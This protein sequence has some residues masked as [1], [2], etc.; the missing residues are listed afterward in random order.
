[1]TAKTKEAPEVEEAAESPD[2]RHPAL[3][4]H[5]IPSEQSEAWKRQ[6]GKIGCARFNGAWYILRPLLRLE[7]R[8]FGRIEGAEEFDIQEKIAARCLL[9]PRVEEAHLRTGSTAGLATA[10]TTAITNLSDYTPDEP[11]SLL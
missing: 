2:D 1:M 6:Y 5:N 7:L 10:L 3:V 4:A 9:A 11:V 8:E